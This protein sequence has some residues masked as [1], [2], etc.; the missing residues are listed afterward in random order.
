MFNNNNNNR[1]I[2]GTN[3]GSVRTHQDLHSTLA[4]LPTR[5]NTRE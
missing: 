3:A 2:S 4:N 5:R 1:I